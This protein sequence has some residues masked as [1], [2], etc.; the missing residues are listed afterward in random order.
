MRDVS[1]SIRPGEIVGLA[2][3]VGSGRTEVARL[4][5]GA[6]APEGGEMRL[7]GKPHAPRSPRDAIRKGIAL[8]PEDRKSQGL[9]M[10]QD[11]QRNV[12]LLAAGRLRR[13]GALSDRAER[14]LAQETIDALAI[15]PP[16]P[17]YDVVGLS[18][19]NQQK[20]L[21]GKWMTIA[22]RLILLD[23]PTRGVDVGARLHIY[24]LITE[25]AASGAAVLLIS[26]ELE[27]VLGLSHRVYLMRDGATVGEADPRTT[28]ADELLFALFNVTRSAKEAS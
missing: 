11:V 4:I 9:V 22:P 13:R 19:G 23:E 2:G 24:N 16:D 14:A 20:A 15:T 7:D 28:T 1:L 25:L 5:F 26:S 8:I 3:L 17:G 12:G 10:T 6:D 18:G 27:E 21:F